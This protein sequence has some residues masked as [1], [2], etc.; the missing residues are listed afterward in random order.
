MIIN[1]INIYKKSVLDIYKKITNKIVSLSSRLYETISTEN[2]MKILDGA[3]I[4]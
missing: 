1:I 4:K 3:F 2:P